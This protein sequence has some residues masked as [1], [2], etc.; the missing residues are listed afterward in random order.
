MGKAKGST[1][2]QQLSTL[3]GS[4]KELQDLLSQMSPEIIGG[5]LGI[6][7]G[8]LNEQFQQSVVDPAMLAYSQDIIPGI[9]ERFGGDTST[10]SA[11]NQT[12]AQSAEILGTQLGSQFGQFA[13]NQ[14]TNQMQA[15]TPL[16]QAMLG[17][18]VENVVTQKSG[19]LDP[20][21][22]AAGTIGGGYLG[23]KF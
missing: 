19:W 23:G 2:T 7:T 6:G 8:D 3:S 17:Q 10:S 16:L 12:L 18:Q 4:Q 21:L 22:G 5:L 13:Q 20:L 9:Q 1:S 11:L 15:L 14:Q